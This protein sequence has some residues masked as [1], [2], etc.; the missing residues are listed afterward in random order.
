MEWFSNS[1]INDA[2]ILAENFVDF[3][4]Y[5]VLNRKLSFTNNIN[6]LDTAQSK[7]YGNRTPDKYFS[8]GSLGVSNKVTQEKAEKFSQKLT[9]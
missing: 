3:S 9:N 5:F 6:W 8:W 7:S 1:D 2:N 4:N